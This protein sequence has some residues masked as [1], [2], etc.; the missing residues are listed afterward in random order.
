M[1]SLDLHCFLVCQSLVESLIKGVAAS[2]LTKMEEFI[3]YQPE[4]RLVQFLVL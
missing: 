3:D 1:A 4:T 2:A